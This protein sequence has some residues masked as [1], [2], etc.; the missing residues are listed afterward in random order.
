MQ[1]LRVTADHLAT[2]SAQLDGVLADNR[3]AL[4]GFMHE[5]LPQIEA[6]ARDSRAAAR[7]FQQL[8]RSLRDNP[9]Q[10]LYQPALPAGVEVA[11]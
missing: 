1:R 11:Q 9:S 7:E 10:L 8:S 6:L 4:A 5:G 3:A 2:A